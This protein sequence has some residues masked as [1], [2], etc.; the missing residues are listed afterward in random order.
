M[1]K[2]GGGYPS[3]TNIPHYLGIWLPS[4]QGSKDRIDAILVPS[5]WDL[6]LFAGLVS[7]EI[8][9]F[10]INVVNRGQMQPGHEHE[11]EMAMCCSLLCMHRGRCRS[12]LSVPNA[13]LG[14]AQQ[15]FSRAALPAGRKM[16]MGEASRPPPSWWALPAQLSSLN[17]YRYQQLCFPTADP[18]ANRPQTHCGI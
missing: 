17:L 1:P 12:E 6:I 14:W 4:S 8:Q 3:K 11:C 18:E 15:F 9:N 2:F 10:N 5:G 13:H 7:S 16:Q